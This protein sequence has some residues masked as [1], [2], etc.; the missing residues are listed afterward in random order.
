MYD[1]RWLKV[2]VQARKVQKD[3]EVLPFSYERRHFFTLP[4]DECATT[5]KKADIKA[6]DDINPLVCETSGKALNEGRA[7]LKMAKFHFCR[8]RR[9]YGV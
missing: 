3:V 1:Y 4:N 9:L 2:T 8:P 5:R 6:Y 7:A